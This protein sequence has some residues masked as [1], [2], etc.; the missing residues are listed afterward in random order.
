LTTLHI[1]AG[2]EPALA[3][4]GYV[5]K[6][7]DKYEIL[8]LLESYHVQGGPVIIIS[9][10]RD[11]SRTLQVILGAAGFDSV[12]FHDGSSAVA[13][14]E[15]SCPSAIFIGSFRKEALE[16]I[17]TGIKSSHRSGNVP[18]YQLLGTTLNRYVTPVT[19]SPAGRKAEPRSLYKLVGK[20]EK[21]FS[22]GLE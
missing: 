8:S 5:S 10:D 12:L 15:A 3:V 22:K 16:E 1:H 4:H 9:P 7:F 19:L 11:E 14:C 2:E 18:I 17:F 20:I 13:A 6:P 21:E